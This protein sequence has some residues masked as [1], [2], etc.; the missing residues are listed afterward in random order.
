MWSFGAC[1][2]QPI[3]VSEGKDR[4]FN[5]LSPLNSPLMGGD[6]RRDVNGSVC[7]S[8]SRCG[9]WG[10]LPLVGRNVPP[11]KCSHLG[12]DAAEAWRSF[13]DAKLPPELG[14]TH[15]GAGDLRISTDVGERQ[16][17]PGWVGRRGSQSTRRAAWL[18]GFVQ[19]NQATYRHIYRQ[20]A[21]IEPMTPLVPPIPARYE[22]TVGLRFPLCSVD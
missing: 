9:P 8:A 18:L 1:T 16:R 22:S 11:P 15:T 6:Y 13:A 4:K 20:Q 3:V 14:V 19:I 7:R 5:R 10:H 21:R 2:I 12:A 17:I